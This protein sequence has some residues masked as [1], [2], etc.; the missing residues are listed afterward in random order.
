M[1]TGV[2]TPLITL[3]ALALLAGCKSEPQRSPQS[4]GFLRSDDESVLFVQWTRGVRQIG[5]TIDILERKPGGEIGTAM[6]VFDGY[7]DGMNVSMHMMSSWTP[8]GGDKGL[9]GKFKG[10]LIGDTLTLFNVHV[11]GPVQFRSGPLQFRRATRA[12]YHE[13]ARQL[14]MRAKLNKGAY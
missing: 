6:L 2:K 7:S 14:E 5:G 10:L 3:L 1:R 11:S 12:E 4:E 13:A 9:T 8:R